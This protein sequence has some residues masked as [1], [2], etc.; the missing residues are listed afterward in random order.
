MCNKCAGL[1]EHD[2]EAKIRLLVLPRKLQ[3]VHQSHEI[4]KK[5]ELE[6]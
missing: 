4:K 1:L 6:L 3:K 5:G 2:F